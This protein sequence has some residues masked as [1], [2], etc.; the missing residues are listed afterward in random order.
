MSQLIARQVMG[1][2]NGA[3]SLIAPMADIAGDLMQLSQADREKENKRAEEHRTELCAAYGYAPSPTVNK[4]FAYADGVAIIPVHGSLINRFGQ[5]WG[6]VTGYNFIT[7][8]LRMALADDDVK[9]IILDCNSPGGEAAGCFETSD[10]IYEARGDK[11]IVA[12]VDSNSMSACYA[13]ASAA[14]KIVVTPTGS[15]GSIGVVAMHVSMEGMLEKA[16]FKVNLIYSG[17]HKVDGNPFQDLPDSVRADIKR[18]VDASRGKFA[19]LVARNRGLDVEAVLKTEAAVYRTEEALQLGLIDEVATPQNAVLNLF[20]E[21]SGS[22]ND[23]PENDM[24]PEDNAQAPA[25]AAAPTAAAPAA[26]APAA[27]APAAAAPAVD[28]SAVQAAERQRCSGILTC[29]A[30]AANPGL[31]NHLA[32]NTS[33]SVD[34]AKQMLAA[35]AP[36]QAAAAPAA[37]APAAAA[38]TNAFAAAMNSGQQ[39]NIG[40]NAEG[41]QA[42]GGAS[43]EKSASFI[44]ASYKQATG[45]DLH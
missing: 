37:A 6:F 22:T 16:G 41:Q 36:A 5:S 11:P 45:Q 3:C 24:P 8:Q 42:A 20:N 7:S 14:D 13:I 1:R 2:I 4:P 33:M 38:P 43:D 34:E 18:G 9:A 26:A 30:A 28:Q 35:S 44:L 10:A 39:P 19:S 27:A 29:E 23:D 32:F 25:T 17:E 12:V 15:V 31:A 40:A 21:L